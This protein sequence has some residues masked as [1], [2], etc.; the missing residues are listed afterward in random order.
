MRALVSNNSWSTPTL[1]GAWGLRSCQHVIVSL[2]E[3]PGA[4][5][6]HPLIVWRAMTSGIGVAPSLPAHPVSRAA[7]RVLFVR[8]RAASLPLRS[9]AR[10]MSP[11]TPKRTLHL[12]PFSAASKVA[13]TCSSDMLAPSIASH[14][15]PRVSC[16][17]RNKARRARFSHDGGGDRCSMALRTAR[18]STSLQNDRLLN[19]SDIRVR[20]HGRSARGVQLLRPKAKSR[21]RVALGY[22]SLFLSLWHS[23]TYCCGPKY[24]CRALS[25]L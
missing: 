1:E 7:E 2:T 4:S 24:K 9:I 14:R 25:R 6:R 23:A 20:T 21:A 3:V 12:S 5:T 13:T 10:R 18:L 17:D 15:A 16:R 11:G 19:G 8:S 22:L